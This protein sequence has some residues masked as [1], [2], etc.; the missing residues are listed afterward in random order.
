MKTNECPVW[1]EL[2]PGHGVLELEEV[3]GRA[4][5]LH[6]T[7]SADGSATAAWMLD[8]GEVLSE[9][10]VPRTLTDESTARYR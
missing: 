3:D 4:L 1:V 9:V 5:E 6:V 8:T 10:A 2:A 7:W